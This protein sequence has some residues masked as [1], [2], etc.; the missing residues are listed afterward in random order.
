[1]IPESI[2]HFLQQQHVP[3]SRHG[4]PR[5][6][7]AQELA[8]SVHVTGYRVAKSV[9]IQAEQ[10][11][12]ICLLPASETLD[13]DKVREALG[14]QEV[15]LATEAEFSNRFPE[16]EL[17]AEPPFG[18]LYGLPVLLDEGLRG[19]EDM[20]LRAGSHEEALSVSVEDFL[21]LESPQV[22]SITQE[23]TRH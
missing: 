22:V 8:Q 15:R 7:T 17:G 13:L 10:H 6:V 19:T 11:L 12:W 9:I 23:R 18:T 16:C 14:A 2:Q 3:F 21:A 4:H 1:M 20:L 5:A